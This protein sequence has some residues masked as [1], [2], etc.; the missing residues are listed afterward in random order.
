[1]GKVTVLRTIPHDSHNWTEGLAFLEGKLYEGT[2]QVGTSRIDVVDPENGA[3]LNSVPLPGFYGEGITIHKQQL[4]QLTYTEKVGFVYDP[5][6]L[7]PLGQFHFQTQTGEGWGLTNDG[8]H[9]IVSDGSANLYFLNPADGSRVATLP[10]KDDRGPVTQ[11]NELEF[12]NGIIFA[13]IWQTDDIVAIHAD[14]GRVLARFDCTALQESAR[15]RD[16]LL[17]GIA[18]DASTDT[19]YLSGK[20]WSKSFAVKLR[21]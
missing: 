5:T 4:T 21:F 1:M 7:K 15:S 11:L 12:V 19:F 17:N 14:T 9:L 6:T 18:Y 20:T 13:N 3:V 10:V 8:E 2:G 16:A